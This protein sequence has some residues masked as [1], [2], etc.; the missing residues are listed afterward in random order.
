MQRAYFVNRYDTFWKELNFNFPEH[1]KNL[2]SIKKSF[3]KTKKSEKKFENFL[4]SRKSENFRIFPKKSIENRIEKNRDFRKFSRFRKNLK[5]S[6]LFSD[7][8]V[9]INDFFMDFK[10]F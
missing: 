1:Q 6:I 5:I 9:F 10:I 4:F 3:R 8:F 7:F 2:K